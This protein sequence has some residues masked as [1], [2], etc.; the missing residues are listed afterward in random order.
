MANTSFNGPVRSE[1][2]F[3]SISKNSSTGA[4]TKLADFVAV[5]PILL[6]SKK[7]HNLNWLF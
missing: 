5:K 2:G 3:E 1:N 4:I 7:C 6:L